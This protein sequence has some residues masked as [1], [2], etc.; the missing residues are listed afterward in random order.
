MS[1]QSAEKYLVRLGDITTQI[2]A[3]RLRWTFHEQVS[4]KLKTPLTKLTGFLSLLQEDPAMLSD[5]DKD[6]LLARANQ[7]AMQLQEQILSIFQYLEV[8]QKTRPDRSRCNLAEIQKAIT[9][10]AACLE[11]KSINIS[12]DGLKIL[13]DTYILTSCEVIELMV[14]EIFENAIKFHPEQSP[15]LE[16]KI[17]NASTGVRLQFFDDGLTLPPDQ[18]VKMWL[19]YYQAEKSFSGQVPGMGLGLAT[20]ASLAWSMGGTCHTYNRTDQSGIMIELVL[21][22]HVDTDEPAVDLADEIAG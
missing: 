18:L 22:S 10:I 13:G 12:H 16:V 6:T 19:P 11:P 21:P 8:S 2:V 7:N 17:S 20:I 1:P 14:W 15:E 9:E 4:H 3:Q 5:E